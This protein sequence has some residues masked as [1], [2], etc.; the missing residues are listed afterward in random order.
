M[1]RLFTVTSICA[2]QNLSPALPST[3]NK[4]PLALFPKIMSFLFQR[5]LGMCWLVTQRIQHFPLVLLNPILHQLPFFFLC[6]PLSAFLSLPLP[7]IFVG[8]GIMPVSQVHYP[9]YRLFVSW[10]SRVSVSLC[11]DQS[12]GLKFR[13]NS[14]VVPQSNLAPHSA[15]QPGSSGTWSWTELSSGDQVPA[16]V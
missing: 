13:H 6:T 8:L 5:I 7:G 4:S 1:S 3:S 10:K 12:R 11:S 2:A 9:G 14:P 16:I 15:F